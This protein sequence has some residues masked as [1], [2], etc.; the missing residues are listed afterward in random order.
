[1][2]VSAFSNF[3]GGRLTE[4]MNQLIEPE[5]EEKQIFDEFCPQMNKLVLEAEERDRIKGIK[6]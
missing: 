5:R 2:I 4:S 1:M 3:F 6:N